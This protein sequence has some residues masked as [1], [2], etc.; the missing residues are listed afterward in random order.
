[1]FLY[2]I[3]FYCFFCKI[4]KITEYNDLEWVFE[5]NPTILVY[6]QI[7]NKRASLSFEKI[8]SSKTITV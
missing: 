6:E 7:R 3:W 4:S 2:G 8:L 1:M 5:L